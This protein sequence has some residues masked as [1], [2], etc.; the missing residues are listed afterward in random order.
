MPIPASLFGAALREYELMPPSGLFLSTARPEPHERRS[1]YITL[2]VSVALFAT[3]APFAG[4]PLPV[5]WVFVPVYNSAIAIN[6]VV[7]AGLLLGQFTILRSSSLLVLAGAYL[8]TGLMAGAHMLSFPGVFSPT[9][10][11]G[12]GEQTTAWLY[13]LWHG[14]FPVMIIAYVLL[15]R[16]DGLPL[17]PAG[18]AAV[19]NSQYHWRGNVSL[20][21]TASPD[22]VDSRPRSAVRQD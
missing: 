5:L 7:T 6:D 14:S 11:L 8:F 2:I 13:V 15:G 10:W 16:S 4:K 20:S 18:H 19:R 17:A 12:A 1:A 21:G 22:R 9:G 3:L